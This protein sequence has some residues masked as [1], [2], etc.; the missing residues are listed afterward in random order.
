MFDIMTQCALALA[1]FLF[2]FLRDIWLTTASMSHQHRV[3]PEIPP[4]TSKHIMYR[5]IVMRH[6]PM[7]ENVKQIQPLNYY[8]L[9][10]ESVHTYLCRLWSLLSFDLMTLG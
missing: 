2:M 4:E 7:T 5:R 3:L 10:V 8:L 1:L 6:Q 9:V